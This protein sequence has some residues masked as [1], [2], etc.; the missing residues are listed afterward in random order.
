MS[1]EMEG[2]VKRISAEKVISDKFTCKEFILHVPGD[3][4]QD[5]KFQLSNKKLDLVNQSMVNQEIKVHFNIQ[6]RGT[7][8][9]YWNNLTC[10]KIESNQRQPSQNQDEIPESQPVP[11]DPNEILEDGIPF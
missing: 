3:Y 1:Y 4:P 7:K 5:I 10:W 9:G 11:Q 8:T 6:G 2:V